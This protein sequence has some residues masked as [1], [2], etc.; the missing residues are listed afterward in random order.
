MNPLNL[1]AREVRA[2]LAGLCE[3]RRPV[4][5]DSTL[6]EGCRADAELWAESDIATAWVDRG[7]SPMGNPGP[8]L[9]ARRTVEGSTHR[10]YPRLWVGERYWIREPWATRRTTHPV[11]DGVD[12]SEMAVR[13]VCYEAT[14]S[15]G[16]RISVAPDGSDGP[17][18]GVLFLYGWT[19]LGR[20]AA[21][22]A[23][24]WRAA[25]TMPRRFSRLD[26]DVVCVS[27]ERVGGVWTWVTSIRRVD[28]ADSEVA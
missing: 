27:P 9:Q 17:P 3:I 12:V 16:L 18:L 22:K 1:D 23:V 10:L 24:R 26:V 14:P 5:L 25:S 19:P 8:Y 28:A 7:P 21:A 15:V 4:T 2:L 13:H 11:R 6:V 20:D